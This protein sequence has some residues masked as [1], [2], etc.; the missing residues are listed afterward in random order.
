MHYR[1]TLRLIPILHLFNVSWIAF[2]KGDTRQNPYFREARFQD[3]KKSFKLCKIYTP[4]YNAS[5][6]TVY[7]PS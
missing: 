2:L 4:I 5:C 7:L 6:Q 1:F 3:F